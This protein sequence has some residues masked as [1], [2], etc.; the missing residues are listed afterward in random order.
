MILHTGH[1]NTVKSVESYTPKNEDELDVV[2]IVD[3][4]D[5]GGG[6]DDASVSIGLV[7]ETCVLGSVLAGAI[8]LLGRMSAY[9]IGPLRHI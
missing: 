3:D 1:R 9:T 4:D 2:I 7:C 6:G 8:G 5:G